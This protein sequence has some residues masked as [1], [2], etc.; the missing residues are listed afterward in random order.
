MTTFAG[1]PP[2]SIL[3][4]TGQVADAIRHIAGDHA[5][6]KALMGPGVDPHLFREK[7]SHVVDLKQADIV[8]YNGLH[9]EGRLVETLELFGKKKPVFALTE[10]LVQSKDKRLR[11]PPEF[12]GYFDP[13]VWHDASLW[14]DCV[15]YAAEK[16]AEFDPPRADD[17]R[18][19]A[20]AYR[21]E[22]ES[23][24]AEITNQIG[25]IAPSQRVLVT[26]HDAFGYFSEAYD[27]ETFG[28][29]GISTEDQADFQHMDEVRSMLVERK[30][31]AVFVE[32][33]TS[34]RLVEQLIEECQ[35]AGHTVR[36]GEELYSD[37]L[38]EAGSGA[39]DYIDMMRAN[40]S[41]IVAGLHAQSAESN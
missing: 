27:I 12:E 1:E 24:H 15:D 11:N 35:S 7:P 6:V 19:R 16:L 8:F 23:L 13:H 21:E 18:S 31:P 37:A 17:Y 29:K 20:A 28:L 22:L 5:Q 2:L 10:Q 4:T 9:L 39:D 34:K 38:G 41:R 36:M 40:A 26:A 32:S 3:C 25:S 33:S 30:I 14:A